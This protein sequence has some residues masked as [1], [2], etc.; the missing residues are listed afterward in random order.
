[1]NYNPRDW[2]KLWLLKFNSGLLHEILWRM[3]G[4]VAGAVVITVLYECGCRW[5]LGWTNLV[6][7]GQQRPAIVPLAAHS[8]AGVA[9]GLLL[10][11][12]T[13]ASYDRFWEGR[14]LW[15]SITNESRNLARQVIVL[16][17]GDRVLQSRA[18]DWIVVLPYTV[19]NQL[20]GGATV[21]AV[22]ERLPAGAGSALLQSQH[23]PLAAAAELT[24]LL[25]EARGRG[26]ISDLVFVA[27]DQNVNQLVDY[28]GGCERIHRT[29][30]P[31]A[32]GVHLRLALLAYCC[33]LPLPLV[34]EFSWWTIP[35]VALIT[36][37]LFGIDEIGLE[38]ENP[39]GGTSHDLPLEEFC[40]RIE[41]NVRE[42]QANRPIKLA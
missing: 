19:M 21:A 27:L 33:T 9:L 13:N 11:L 5:G 37:I 15:G 38:I 17:G 1:M 31:F 2:R 42:L 8:L 41:Q 32:Y 40:Q 6:V 10:V 16:L 22:A 26:L 39:F 20:Y 7:T 34:Q 24:S 3:V 35:A 28:L 29:P 4:C 14:R 30:L 18:L 36:Y 12:R 25:A 23:P